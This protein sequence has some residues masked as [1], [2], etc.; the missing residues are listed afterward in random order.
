ML[1]RRVGSRST[2]LFSSLLCLA[3]LGGCRE[4]QSW[5][6]EDAEVPEQ[7]AGLHAPPVPEPFV[8]ALE[9]GKW[10]ALSF[11]QRKQFMLEVVLPTV[12]PLLKEFDP[13]RF[14]AVSCK[15]CHGQN[16]S[17][18]FAMPSADLPALS[19]EALKN[20]TEEQKPMVEFMKSTLR[21]KMSELLGMP[22]ASPLRCN[23]CHNSAS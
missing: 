23:A 10:D 20:P 16:L 22:E 9:E 2:L 18:D 3:A 5:P 19:S 21:P 13:A 8:G 11:D 12:G 17:R 1:D 4:S 14:A 7:D 15:T 6:V